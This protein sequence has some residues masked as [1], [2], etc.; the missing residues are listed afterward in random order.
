MEL[1]PICN[2][3]PRHFREHQDENGKNIIVVDWWSCKK[4]AKTLSAKEYNELLVLI[5]NQ[6]E[7]KLPAQK[8]QASLF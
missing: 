7:Q 3:R 5:F 1:C 4:C 8:F 2:L 6:P